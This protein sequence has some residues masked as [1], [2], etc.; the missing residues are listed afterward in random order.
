MLSKQRFLSKRCF[1]ART[2]SHSTR[3]QESIM[4]TRAD[5]SFF[6]PCL[7]LSVHKRFYA[8]R[9]LSTHS[10]V[11]TPPSLVYEYVLPFCYFFFFLHRFLFRLPSSV[12][13]S[14]RSSRFVGSDIHGF[15]QHRLHK[16]HYNA[17]MD[18]GEWP[19]PACREPVH[20][21]IVFP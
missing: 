1:K 18:Q 20:S 12:F 11:L 14:L 10:R 19:Y 21:C 13:I 2:P 17:E 3:Q 6:A 8:D 16:S 9:H 4:A 5:R 15:Q 7:I